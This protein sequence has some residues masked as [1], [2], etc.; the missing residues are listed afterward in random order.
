MS[1]DILVCVFARMVDR[2]SDF[3]FIFP[4]VPYFPGCKSTF[5]STKR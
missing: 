5:H 1:V 4:R 2:C 3:K